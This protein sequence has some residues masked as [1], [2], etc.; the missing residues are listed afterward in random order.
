MMSNNDEFINKTLPYYEN[1]A[2]I[3]DNSVAN[4]QFARTSHKSLATEVGDNTQKDGVGASS[5]A[6][7]NPNEVA[8]SSSDRLSKES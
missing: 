7:I 2:T 6:A 5:S 1:L 3:F 4:G 8:S